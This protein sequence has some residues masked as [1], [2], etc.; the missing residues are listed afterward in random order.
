MA[1]S[2]NT[3]GIL[4]GGGGA[5]AGAVVAKMYVDKAM[6]EAVKKDGIDK[7]KLT[8][9]SE[10]FAKNTWAGG[11]AG[12]VV[13]IGALYA[14]KKKE[15]ILPAFLAHAAVV[16]PLFVLDYLAK[17]SGKTQAEIDALPKP[18]AA[19]AAGA[20][21]E[22]PAGADVPKKGAVI[23]RSPFGIA[24]AERSP[25]S[26]PRVEMFAAPPQLTLSGT[27]NTPYTSSSMQSQMAA[28]PVFGGQGF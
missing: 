7:A 21:A 11:V 15:A 9:I 14:M 28:M 13:A 19:A 6:V 8:G 10:F 4:S 17:Q 26:A 1:L 2:K 20:G 5:I 18:A 22:A 3:L 27:S 16:A 12:G 25:F 23:E 24:V